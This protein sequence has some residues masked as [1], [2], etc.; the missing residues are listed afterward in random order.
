MSDA[1]NHL[2]VLAPGIVRPNCCWISAHLTAGRTNCLGEW[3][4]CFTPL[5]RWPQKESAKSWQK[6]WKRGKWTPRRA[7][8]VEWKNE[9][10]E[11]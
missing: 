10:K 9:E 5:R 4:D 1:I 8:G 6:L 7:S 11:G 3:L 2:E